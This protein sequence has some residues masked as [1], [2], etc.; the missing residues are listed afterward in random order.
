M[1][2]STLAIFI[3]VGIAAGSFGF[4]RYFPGSVTADNERRHIIYYVD[5]MHPSYKSTQPGIAPDCGMKLV[6]VYQDENS[7]TASPATEIPAGQVKI[8][9]NS[10]QKLGIRVTAA[11]KG[12][13]SQL[14]RV[15]GRVSPEDTRIYS[16]NTGVDGFI[17]E[18]YNDSVGTLVKKDQ[19]I[20]AYYAPDFVAAASGFLA[21]T[22][23]VPGSVGKDGAR[24]SPNFPGT[25]AKEGVRSIQGYTD[26]LRNL[27][28]SDDQI[29]RM[30]D[31]RELPDSID[32]VSPTDGLILSRNVSRGQHFDHMMEFYKIADISRVWVVAE[33]YEDE[34]QY[35][36]PGN[37]AQISLPDQGRRMAAQVADSLPQSEIGGGTEKIRLEVDNSSYVLRPD[38]LVDVE[39][40]VRIPTVVAVPVDAVVNSGQHARVYVEHGNEI[41][42][43]RDVEIG[44]RLGDQIEILHGLQVGERVVSAATFFVDSESRMK[45]PASAPW[46][47]S[48]PH[49]QHSDKHGPM[50]AVPTMRDPM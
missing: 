40:S 35:L 36:R 3:V 49:N 24:F 4:A 50:A 8:D 5:P 15:V 16:I 41:F 9:E 18:T 14:V 22:E 7:S 11:E 21:A 45:S 12:G 46:M 28:M 26:H 2:R 43:P 30:A 20:A 44:R 38:M 34:A 42:E 6:P 39:I 48:D 47:S 13:T 23:R 32:V 10:Q 27:G 19:K 33:V 31:T 17:R 1:R 37:S 29:K 25:I